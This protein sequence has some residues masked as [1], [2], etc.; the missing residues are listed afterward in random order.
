MYMYILKYTWQYFYITSKPFHKSFM[1]TVYIISLVYIIGQNHANCR[2]F[3]S[4]KKTLDEIVFIS[5]RVFFLRLDM[6]Q[7]E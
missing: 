4:L 1:Y 2:V 7:W 5:Q 3:D 6:Q